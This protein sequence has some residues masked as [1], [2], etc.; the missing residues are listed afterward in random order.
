MYLYP[1]VRL[2]GSNPRLAYSSLD[3]LL[4]WEIVI[5]MKLVVVWV[6]PSYRTVK[7]V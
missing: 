6:V 4:Y 3:R 2:A 1:L 5:P 7:S